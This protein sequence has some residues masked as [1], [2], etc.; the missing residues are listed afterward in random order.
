MKDAL[1][2]INYKRLP[3]DRRNNVQLKITYYI[4]NKQG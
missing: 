3:A 4:N 1:E 2:K